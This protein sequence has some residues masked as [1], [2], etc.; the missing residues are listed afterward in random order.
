MYVSRLT[1]CR[2][3]A[4]RGD[5]AAQPLV[6]RLDGVRYAHA[7]PLLSDGDPAIDPGGA[8]D[9]VRRDR[10]IAPLQDRLVPKQ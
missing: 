1:D 5:T 9:Q 6:F 10:R 2:P 3:R 4:L 7:L 8:R